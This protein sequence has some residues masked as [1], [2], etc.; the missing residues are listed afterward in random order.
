[1]TTHR[2]SARWLL[3]AI[4]LLAAQVASGRA[5]GVK[6]ALATVDKALEGVNEFV[7]RI[8]YDETAV[9]QR[10]RGAGTLH[11]RSD[12]RVRAEIGGESPRT[13]LYAPPYLY[14]HRH[15]AGSVERFDVSS[16]PGLLAQ[17]LAYGFNPAGRAL[18]KRFD[19]ELVG[20]VPL[21]ER[22]ALQF[23]LTPKDDAVAAAV[24]WIRLWVDPVSGVPLRHEIVQTEGGA[25]LEVRYH[26]VEL[27]RGEPTGTYVGGWPAGTTILAR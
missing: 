23:L 21:D 18:R 7:A 6:Q 14:I 26:D 4:V 16:N 11:V 25:R 1:M 9:G 13:V 2:R 12:G 10:V 27:N 8:E 5:P 24:A 15:A 17:Y 22:P 3:P 19:V 20:S